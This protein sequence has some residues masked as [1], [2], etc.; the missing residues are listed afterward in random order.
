MKHGLMVHP[1]GDRFAVESTQRF[2]PNRRFWRGVSINVNGDAVLRSARDEVVNEN[3]VNPQRGD[4]E[5]RAGL[6]D[7]DMEML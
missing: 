6:R 4:H 1:S 2:P 7:G 3:L 5:K